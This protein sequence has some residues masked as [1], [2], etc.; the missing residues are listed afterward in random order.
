MNPKLFFFFFWS[1]I[2]DVM[3][4]LNFTGFPEISGKQCRLFPIQNFPCKILPLFFRRH[5]ENAEKCRRMPEN[6]QTYLLQ[7]LGILTAIDLSAPRRHCH[8]CC[9][10]RRHVTHHSRQHQVTP[11][12][13]SPSTTDASLISCCSSQASICLPPQQTRV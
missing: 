5:V 9:H 3:N 7:I 13:L 1:N 6:P 2:E 11:I 4:F 12:S 10:C 8:H